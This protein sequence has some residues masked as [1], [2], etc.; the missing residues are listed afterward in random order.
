MQDPGKLMGPVSEQPVDDN[1]TQAPYESQPRVTQGSALSSNPPS[2]SGEDVRPSRWEPPSDWK[3]IFPQRR[4]RNTLP[5]IVLS[6]QEAQLI[7]RALDQKIARSEQ[8]ISRYSAHCMN[9]TPAILK[10][11]SRSADALNELAGTLENQDY[12]PRG[13][14]DEIA[15][16]RNA[17]DQGQTYIGELAPSPTAAAI[18]RLTREAL[19]PTQPVA[20]TSQTFDFG[21]PGGTNDSV[22]LE[23]RVSTLEVKV[24]DFEY[25]IAKLQRAVPEPLTIAKAARRRSIHDLFPDAQ[26]SG[27]SNPHISQSGT[28]LSS[29]SDSPV[30]KTSVNFPAQPLRLSRSDTIRP[31]VARAQSR[32]RQLETTA[33]QTMNSK[34]NFEIILRLVREE[35]AA[36]Q[37][38]EGQ[39]H[40]LQKEVDDLRAPVYAYIRP[41][42]NPTP[43]PESKYRTPLTPKA[44]TLH[45]APAFTVHPKSTPAVVETSRFS[46]S[47]DDLSLSDTDDS[48]RFQD[49]YESSEEKRYTF[50]TSRS[51]VSP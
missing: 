36:R 2:S 29:S 14:E 20:P 17:A 30:D 12:Q 4:R 21:M 32:P 11:R 10:R 15:Y 23:Q 45:R 3:T 33:A 50:E 51:H 7:A 28:F 13:R 46:T 25:A 41:V 26:T 8:N 38:L 18:K 42:T 9:E 19:T 31:S 27:P 47:D 48:N 24:V 5:S 16:W 39:V 22:S 49:V 6:Q 1:V 35:Q 43:S 37:R 44:R 40:A 34:N